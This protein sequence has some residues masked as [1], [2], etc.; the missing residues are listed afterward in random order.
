MG[1]DLF[2]INDEE[3]F[4]KLQER[5]EVIT[6]VLHD[7]IKLVEH[8]MLNEDILLIVIK[9]CRI[10]K[11]YLENCI[12]CHG[13]MQE[14]GITVS[15]YRHQK[16]RRINEIL[17]KIR[18]NNVLILNYFVDISNNYN[19]MD[20]NVEYNDIVSQINVLLS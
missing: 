20:F 5:H 1:Y 10:N 19:E 17:K 8:P 15:S 7:L 12:D 18:D 13:L 11:R 4:N 3:F 14:N 16:Y 2:E 9:L 6:T